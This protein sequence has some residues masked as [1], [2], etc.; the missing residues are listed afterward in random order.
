[1]NKK[2][3]FLFLGITSV[4]VGAGAGA[5]SPVARVLEVKGKIAI[6][7]PDKTDRAAA[8]FS[9]IYADDRLVAAKG[10]QATLLF[11]SD[12]HIERVVSPG[13]FQ[14]SPSGCQP[15][16]GVEQVVL[17]AQSQAVVL[18]ISQGPDGIVQGGV[19]VA[20]ASPPTTDTS[21]SDDEPKASAAPRQIH[22]LSE[23]TLLAAKPTFSWPSEAKAK[24]YQLSLYF[25]GNRVWSATSETAQLEFAAATPLNAGAMY[26]WEVTAE[27]DGESAKICEGVFYTA[28]DRQRAEA[29]GL[30]K[31]LAKPD[32]PRLAM[33]AVWY[34]QNRFVTEAIAVHEQLAKLNNDAAVY[35]A[36]SELCWQAGR[37]ED[38]KA[39]ASKAAE[40]DKKTG[41][42]RGKEAE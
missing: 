34:K 25:R 32:V 11:R 30:V 24:K 41:G 28:S 2:W 19:V 27:L 26:S 5:R 3:T 8:M 39:A 38:A 22:P 12:G 37:E 9:I 10:A 20:R 29:E 15:K 21:S 1:M 18:K 17:S 40:L 31:L 13:T 6:V 36:L 4:V 35:W 16:N 33:A 7:N 14:V 42:D 23:S